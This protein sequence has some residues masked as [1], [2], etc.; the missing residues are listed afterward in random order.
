MQ[1]APA[2]PAQPKEPELPPPD[3]SVPTYDVESSGPSLGSGDWWSSFGLTLCGKRISNDVA[4]K[5]IYAG[6]T[7]LAIVTVA[8]VVSVSSTPPPA[9]P[10]PTIGRD[11]G[12]APTKQASPT[13]GTVP[14]RPAGQDPPPPPP[15]HA[16]VYYLAKTDEGPATDGM[17]RVDTGT[18]CR[19]WNRRK[20]S[21][22][23][24]GREIGSCG[25]TANGQ[26]FAWYQTYS[27][28]QD[29]LCD[30]VHMG[31]PVRSGCSR[32]P[33]LPSGYYVE[34]CVAVDA[35]DVLDC[36]ATE[37]VGLSSD[38]APCP[39]P[40]RPP[41][42]PAPAPGAPPPPPSSVAIIAGLGDNSATV[43]SSCCTSMVCGCE[44]LEGC[45]VVTDST[46]AWV[47]PSSRFSTPE[48]VS[49]PQEIFS[50]HNPYGIYSWG[51]SNVLGGP[52]RERRW[53]SSAQRRAQEIRHLCARS[54][55]AM[56]PTA[57]STTQMTVGT[58]SHCR[59]SFS[60]SAVSSLLSQLE[61]MVPSPPSLLPLPPP[62]PFPPPP[63][64]PPCSPPPGGH[65]PAEA[66]LTAQAC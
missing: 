15:P 33:T 4:K 27:A 11:Q 39:P 61:Q 38:A 9:S 55:S 48:P 41:P 22:E 52:N 30:G 25:L 65:L 44:G 66:V 28:A 12:P 36:A 47:S 3:L 24:G 56:E 63:L 2:E 16:A 42:P 29:P 43:G 46:Y 58:I 5:V 32:T 18:E 45:Q 60:G 59:S 50:I 14:P 35:D 62:P 13:Q 49:G 21:A 31:P 51:P 64:P 17:R 26:L 19:L 34:C 53:I 10:T 1:I 57:G 37:L 20:P 54:N 40:T 23:G 6:A 8:L 7:A